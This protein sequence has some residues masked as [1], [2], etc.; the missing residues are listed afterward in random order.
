MATKEKTKAETDGAGASGDT[1]S[2]IGETSLG[3]DADRHVHRI[4]HR[5]DV[6]QQLLERDPL[7]HPP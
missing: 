7:V 4:H 1:L 3:V 2:I 5:S 6:G